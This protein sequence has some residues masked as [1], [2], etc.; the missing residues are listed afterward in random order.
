MQFVESAMQFIYMYSTNS[1]NASNKPKIVSCCLFTLYMYVEV[2]SGDSTCKRVMFLMNHVLG[3]G[4][5]L[6]CCSTPP[7]LSLPTMQMV[8]LPCIIESHK[9]LDKKT[10][11]KTG[12]VSQMMVCSHETLDIPTENIE[13]L[14]TSR[15]KEYLRKLTWSHGSEWSV[16]EWSVCVCVVSACVRVCVCVCVRACMCVCVCVCGVSVSVI[17]VCIHNTMCITL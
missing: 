6:R 10:L 5:G 12:D 2:F 1:Q 14:P 4:V 7:I 3:L 17:H 16:C 9:T 11:Y 15:R 8:D 13:E